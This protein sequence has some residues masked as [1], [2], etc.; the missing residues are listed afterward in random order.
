MTSKNNQV[1]RLAKRMPLTQRF[2]LRKL[3]IGVASVLLGT[4]IAMGLNGEIAHADM[5]NNQSVTMDSSSTPV[6][7]LVST[8]TAGNDQPAASSTAVDDIKVTVPVDDSAYTVNNVKA[9]SLQGNGTDHT[10]QTNLSFDL[11]VDIAHHDIKAGDYINV[12]MGI[13]YRLTANN[14]QYTL[15]YG[16]SASQPVP[17]NVEYQTTSGQNYSSVIGYMRPITANNRS[18]AVSNHQSPVPDPQNV[19]WRPATNDNSLGSNGNGGANDS[20][21]IVFNDNLTNIKSQYGD[22]NLSMARMHFNL[23]WHNITGFDL[24][25]A[26]LD[27]RYFHL[28]SATAAV[29]RILVPEN[30]IQIGDKKFTSGFKIPIVAKAN[31]KDNF[32]QTILPESASKYAA[33]TWYYNLQTQEWTLG[34]EALRYPDHVEAVGLASQNADG[35]ELGRQFKITVTKPAQNDYVDYQFISNDDVKTAIEKSVITDFQDYNL[36][37]VTGATDTYITRKMIS[38]LPPRVTVESK[39]ASD[40]LTRTYTIT[41]DGNYQGFKKDSGIGL[42][43]WQPK[44]L[45]GVL[46]PENIKSPDEDRILTKGYYQGVALRNTGLQSFLEQHPWRLIVTNN[47]G[48]ELLNQQAGY[49]IQPYVYRDD[50]TSNSGLLTGTVNNVENRQV[51][52]TIH[53]VFKDSGNEAAPKYTAELGFARINENGTWQAWTPVNDTFDAVDVP[54]IAGFHAVDESGNPVK[55]ID[56][57]TVQHDSPDIDITVYYVADP[58]LLTYTVIDDDT[59]AVLKDRV[60]LAKGLSD[61]ALPAS[62]ANDYQKIID[63]YLAAGYYLV[64]ANKLPVTFD[65][66]TS[67]NQNVTIYIAKKNQLQTDKHQVTRTITYYDKNTGK[68]L[69]IK[70]VIQ[71]VT[72]TRQAIIS[73]TNGTVV[74]YTLNGKQ[75]KNGNYIVEEKDG[76]KAWQLSAGNWAVSVNPVLTAKGYDLAE[77]ESGQSYPEVAAEQP[78]ALTADKEIKVFYPE[79]VLTTNEQAVTTRTINYVYANGL[80][81]GKEAAPS[82]HQQ[83]IFERTKSV[84]QVTGNT[85]YGNWTAT[86]DHFATVVSPA[87]KYYVPDQE[88]VAAFQVKPGDADIL[89]TVN[90]KT[91][92]NAVTYTVIDDTDGKTLVDH[93]ALA[94]GFAEEKLPAGADN[95]YRTVISHYQQLGYIIVSQDKLPTI[96]THEDQNIVIHILLKNSL[97]AERQTT[98]RTITYYDRSTGKQIMIDGITEPVMQRATFLRQA[99]VAGPDHQVIGYTM[100]EKQDHNGNYLIEVPAGDA[101]QAWKLVNGGWPASPNPDLSYYG[102]GSAENESSNDYPVVLAGNPT[103]LEPSQSIKVYYQPQIKLSEERT[104]TLRTIH[105]VYA[106]GPRKGQTAAPDV[107][108]LVTFA[109]SVKTNEVTKEINRGE[110]QALQSKTVKDGNTVTEADLTSFAAVDSP[111]INGYTPDQAIV[112]N[113]LAIQGAQ[114]IE[115]TV[116]YT[117]EPHKIT[118]SVIDDTTNLTLINHAQLGTGYADEQ[119]PLAINEAYQNAGMHYEQL[120]YK[121]VSQEQ[122]PSTFADHDLNVVIHLAHGT[123]K[124]TDQRVINEDIRYQFVDGGI[125]APTYHAAPIVF[126]RNGVVDQVTGKTSWQAWEPVNNHFTPVISPLV[127]GYVTET[128]QIG[129][130]YV[131][132]DSQDLH[133]I[134]LYSRKPIVPHTT[135]EKPDTPVVPINPNTPTSSETSSS[136]PAQPSD[137]PKSDV[138]ATSSSA[139]V[140]GSSAVPDSNIPVIPEKPTVPPSSATPSSDVPSLPEQ[141]AVPTSNV[142]STA[143]ATPASEG[144]PDSATQP[145][146]AK[147]VVSEPAVPVTVHA[148]ASEK[149]ADNTSQPST[150]EKLP[151]TGNQ[152][153]SIWRIIL[154]AFL[155]LFGISLGKRRKRN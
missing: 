21:Q 137:T 7:A 50:V 111:S 41:I 46:P 155:G 56:K 81:K 19:T 15:S 102:Y 69:A 9:S 22:A 5:S 115:V 145:Q 127:D 48:Q 136:T 47:Q 80:S 39:D 31:L 128:L 100:D 124:V 95:T 116:N 78:T 30:D 113:E 119:L 108:Q 138:P 51:K 66:D 103:A 1:E 36:D 79:K 150:T 6:P 49:Y 71:T 17:I 96:F 133:F 86:N 91:A 107:Q 118:Y 14:Q 34:D 101:D 85:E 76:N 75:D 139:S 126:T 144:I 114:P 64:K 43:S 26:P 104:N 130:Q 65:N 42:I 90:Y 125:A 121:L 89:V 20:Y 88:A 106:N 74:G 68:Q 16:G 77:N 53:Y 134:V 33:H 142:P 60:L 84:N 73:G 93:Q 98:T 129:E 147:T 152:H 154:G 151:Q 141:P 70:L 32:N 143:S 3:S 131:T 40:G 97:Q 11:N 18:Y 37:P 28:Y 58:Q 112:A 55:A 25:E 63:G 132:A 24:D 149:A 13:P 120:G 27:T 135:P 146:A 35:I 59:K 38:A 99:I 109:R 8:P 57:I 82:K 148:T 92:P 2:A 83:V 12:S 105:Y 117:A 4:S 122:L 62:T 52:E 140:P 10:G 123:K 153:Q 44:D 45:N 54:E 87:I 94:S 67:V 23:T 110:W 29:P 61:E 72:F